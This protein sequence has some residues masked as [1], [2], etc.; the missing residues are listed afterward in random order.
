[1]CL[2][3]CGD[4]EAGPILTIKETNISTDGDGDFIIEGTTHKKSK[5]TINDY[6]I[7]PKIA[8][9]GTFSYKTDVWDLKNLMNVED[10]NN[11]TVKAVKGDNIEEI[12]IVIDTQEYDDAI[13]A[14]V[15]GALETAKNAEPD[16]IADETGIIFE[17][18][19][20][21]EDWYSLSLYD[22]AEIA[23]DIIDS[24]IKRA[25]DLGYSEEQVSVSGYTK[26][27]DIAFQSRMDGNINLHSA[28]NKFDVYQR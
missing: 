20:V 9:D 8:A 17:Y 4:E 3:V 10:V 24:Y 23:I 5:I 7:E 15:D 2:I 19:N 13:N 21:A 6:E 12:N 25:E 1:M 14:I 27:G 16:Y 11:I 26:S 22:Q 28:T 18:N